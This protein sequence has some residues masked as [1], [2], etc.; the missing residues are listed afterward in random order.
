MDR[1]IS[2]ILNTVN[3][4]YYYGYNRAGRN[5]EPRVITDDIWL[6]EAW[7]IMREI[8]DP[9]GYR[10]TNREPNTEEEFRKLRVKYL[11]DELSEE[12]WKV[13]LQRKDANF[14]RAKNQVRELF[15]GACR[16]T[17]RQLLAPNPNKPEIRRQIEELVGYCNTSYG[18]I[19]K[20]FGR[21]TPVIEVKP[22]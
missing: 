5:R 3:T 18:D 19:S 21:K 20:R 12:D 14:Q 7:R 22:V 10:H 11:A 16:D 1:Q 4:N 9:Y 17:F 13:A 6:A 2:R 15:L 8:E